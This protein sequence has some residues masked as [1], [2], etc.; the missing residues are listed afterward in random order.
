M[1]SNI[2]R[3]AFKA[4]SLIQEQIEQGIDENGQKYEYSTKTFARP[5]TSRV[6]NHK[7]LIKAQQIGI[8]TT[9]AG[10]RW[11]LIKGGYKAFRAMIGRNPDGDFLQDTGAMLQALS[12][13]KKSDTDA[14]IY[15]TSAKAAQK[16]F[17]LSESGVGKSR[18]TWKFM[19]LTAANKK[20]L[21]EFAASIVTGD[22][23]LKVIK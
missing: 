15:F 13:K 23:I 17:W 20:R 22:E 19:G 2:E 9:K 1:S 10:K 3:V 4:L 21:E 14:V 7:A 8:I 5:F 11:M 18:K 12:V 16:A 6:K